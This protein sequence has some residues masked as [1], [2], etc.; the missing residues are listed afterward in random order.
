MLIIRN[1]DYIKK[2]LVNYVWEIYCSAE[3][4]TARRRHF[5][6]GLIRAMFYWVH[7]LRFT[8]CENVLYY[9]VN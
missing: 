7:I 5:N 2:G 4:L 3:D 6:A 9:L 8:T 1:S